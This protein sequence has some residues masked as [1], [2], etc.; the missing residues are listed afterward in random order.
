MNTSHGRRPSIKL[1][2][3]P[4]VVG[5][6]VSAASVGSRDAPP[7]E[8][9]VVF[10]N[11]SRREAYEGNLF[12]LLASPCDEVPSDSHNDIHD[13]QRLVID[14][15]RSFGSLIGIFP[16]GP[17]LEQSPDYSEP[18]LSAFITNAGGGGSYADLGLPTF[19]IRP[20]DDAARVPTQYCLWI[21]EREEQ[22]PRW[23]AVVTPNETQDLGLRM[24]GCENRPEDPNIDLLQVTPQTHPTG[25]YPPTVRLQW[26][27]PR[28][29]G[30]GQHM[31]GI[32]GREAWL[33][34]T[35]NG[36]A[37]PDIRPGPVRERVPGWFDAQFL[38]VGDS[39]NLSPGPWGEVYPLM[40]PR[41]ELGTTSSGFQPAAR[42]VV[43]GTN[44]GPYRDK[45]DVRR[46]S[47][48]PQPP[49]TEW[50]SRVEI[51][52]SNAKARYAGGREVG[53]NTGTGKNHGPHGSARFR[54]H[55]VDD[56][57]W[58]PCEDWGCCEPW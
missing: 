7:Q 37:P 4:V 44:P 54:W 57:V 40:P 18:R 47:A 2:I 14:N 10:M 55:E 11:E 49:P 50:H 53:L 33:A 27:L 13:C 51:D 26:T 8:R 6:G 32:R 16:Y 46:S 20:H 38:A 58:V 42:M 19:G 17:T 56:G 48:W 52:A 25:L 12:T 31:I 45:W 43:Y 34:V 22:Q 41:A 23:V 28:N 9:E 30:Q 36:V 24:L 1:L 5:L 35:P 39:G 29:R 15:G 21:H 3:L